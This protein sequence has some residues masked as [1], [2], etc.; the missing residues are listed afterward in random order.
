MKI[1][2]F[3]WPA[4]AKKKWNACVKYKNGKR[5]YK[6]VYEIRKQDIFVTH[7]PVSMFLL[8][9]HINLSSLQAKHSSSGTNI[10]IKKL[11]CRCYQL[12]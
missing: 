12:E 7:N 4:S 3:V 1:V 11:K 10:S 8:A 5:Y 9:V 2:L 6:N